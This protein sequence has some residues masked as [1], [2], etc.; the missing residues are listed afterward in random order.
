[1]SDTVG[2]VATAA[3][4]PATW[5]SA[6]QIA[7][8]SGIPEQVIVQ[9]FGLRGKHLAGA[10]EH[11]SDLAASAGRAVLAETGTDP[12][13]VDAVVYFGSTWKDHPVWQAAPRVAHLLGCTRAFALELDY[14]SCGAPVALRVARDLM[15]AEPHLATV[16]LVAGSRESDLVDYANPRARFAYPFGDGAVAGL[17]ARGAQGG[18]IL[19]SHMITD[20][21]L[22]GQVRVPAGGSV[23]PAS[24]ASVRAGRHRLD[25]ADPAAMKQRL[26]DVS[27]DNFVTVAEQA[28]KRSG[29]SLVDLDYLCPI[30]VKPSMHAAI[31][32]RLGLPASAA[33]YLDDTGH[34]SGVD[35][36]LGYDRGR[37]SGA[38]GDGAHVLMLAAGTGY[39]WAATVLRAGNGERA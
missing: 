8:E 7:A 5:A 29:L 20:G 10:H 34:M 26:D 23:E 24:V 28:A 4:L 11:A 18:E 9:K 2:L 30:H 12:D 19:G 15:V 35:P 17:L 37:R 6:A 36:L 14:V 1:M 31:L 33:A 27:L 21:S 13:S 32:D 25:V 38:I 22:A 3:Y 16:L 39:S